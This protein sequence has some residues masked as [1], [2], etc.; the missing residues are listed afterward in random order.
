MNENIHR[1]TFREVFNINPRDAEQRRQ[2]KETAVFVSFKNFGQ[3]FCHSFMSEKTLPP[4]AQERQKYAEEIAGKYGC[5]VSYRAVYSTKGCIDNLVKVRNELIDQMYVSPVFWTP[6]GNSDSKL[7][8]LKTFAFGFLPYCEKQPFV[9]D[10]NTEIEVYET[11]K[12]EPLTNGIDFHEEYGRLK[13]THALHTL[14]S[15]RIKLLRQNA[16]PDVIT[17]EH[18]DYEKDGELMY[19]LSCGN[20]R[21]IEPSD[22][23]KYPS[24]MTPNLYF[25]A[26]VRDCAAEQFLIPEHKML[27]IR[28]PY[29]YSLPENEQ[30]I[31]ENNAIYE[32]MV[33]VWRLLSRRIAV[34][35]IMSLEYK[36]RMCYYFNYDDTRFDSINQHLGFFDSWTYNINDY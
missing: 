34:S 22:D 10:D 17:I 19:Y 9:Y 24:N 14:I 5:K 26:V 4:D 15:K 21:Y 25:R 29:K 28:L 31:A 6:I 13:S 30:E 35:S 3:L 36:D 33:N 8:H 32:Q 11:P 16:Q 7:Y 2:L 23:S 27:F 1:E 18:Y 20:Y 12:I